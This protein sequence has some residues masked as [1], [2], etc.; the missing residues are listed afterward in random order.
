LAE[1]ADVNG[2]T[3]QMQGYIER[4]MG[5]YDRGLGNCNVHAAAITRMLNRLG[6]QAA[7]RSPTGPGQHDMTYLPNQDI[8]I[9]VTARQF[10][11]HPNAT[12][13]LQTQYYREMMQTGV[14]TRTE[15]NGFFQSLYGPKSGF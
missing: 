1:F 11:N 4:R 5:A 6:M 15:Y 10:G 2:L 7:T 12:A 13:N 8:I 14:W 3:P 9:D